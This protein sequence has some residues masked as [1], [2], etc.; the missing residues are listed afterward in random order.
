MISISSHSVY[1]RFKKKK[2]KWYQIKKIIK[3]NFTL[4]YLFIF[5]SN[6]GVR[7]IYVHLD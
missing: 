5:L 2:T 6:A 4:I 1:S 3:S 7:S